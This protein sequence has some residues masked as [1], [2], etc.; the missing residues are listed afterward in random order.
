[1]RSMIGALI[2]ETRFIRRL[3]RARSFTVFERNYGPIAK[4]TSF[5]ICINIHANSPSV[6]SSIQKI[7]Y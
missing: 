5:W 1:M 4:S 7:E 3:G 6:K 2:L